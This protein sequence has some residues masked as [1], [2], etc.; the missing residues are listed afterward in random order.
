MLQLAIQGSNGS[1]PF[2][3]RGFLRTLFTGAG[4]LSLPNLLRQ[5]A[6]AARAGRP[7]RDTA[8]IQLWL[9][10]GPSH[11]DMYD[12]KPD[13]PEGY[14]GP[15]KPIASNLPG[16]SICELMPRQT[17]ILNQL[18][19][20]RSLRHNHNGAHYPA[21]HWMQTGYD[22]VRF[23]PTRPSMGSI[24]AKLR[25]ANAPNLP[26]YV[27]IVTEMKHFNVGNPNFD[28]AYLGTR[29]APM[30]IKSGA[31]E[32]PWG[33]V[34]QFDTPHMAILP[35]MSLARLNNRTQLM[36]RFDHLNRR[37]D[38]TQIMDTMDRYQQQA[39]GLVTSPE[40]RAAFDLSRESP[41]L[42]DRYG[43]NA[44]GQGALLCRRLVEAGVTFITL[45]TDSSSI[46]WDHHRNSK[47]ECEAQLPVYDQMLTALIEDLIDR[48][49]YDR[50]LVLVCGE[51]G[52]SPRI[53]VD[54]GR[55]H[56]GKASFAL[57]GGA[58]LR[59]GQVIGSTTAKGEEPKERA[60]GPEDLLATVYHVLGID[61][62]TELRDFIGRPLPVLDSGH[63]IRELI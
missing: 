59:V 21:I 60:L 2:S 11:I 20:V 39:L 35:D 30:K 10:G 27:H 19:L 46:T 23:P 33:S 6:E 5:R 45:N 9:G 31:S 62:Q 12:M 40:A 14:R 50:V 56:W 42:R 18:S 29:F 3:R 44:W 38:A 4:A 1:R 53:N 54:G 51:F 55:E 15:F 7:A 17:R 26:P 13:A 34:I 48:G 32:P 52:R 41:R 36:H 57:L 8:V 28:A 16:V 63:V 22:G 25:G 24:T 49:L 47:S 61:P 43:M 37:I 58:G